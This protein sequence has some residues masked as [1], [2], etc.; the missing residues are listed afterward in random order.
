VTVITNS[1]A[2]VIAAQSSATAAVT[3]AI[4]PN[5]V[6]GEGTGR[7][8]HPTLGTFDYQYMPEQW[9]NMDGSAIIKPSWQNSKT[10]DSGQNTLWGGNIKDVECKEIWTAPGGLAMPMSQLRV[11]ISFFQNPPDPTVDYVQWWPSY[12]TTNGF[13]VVIKG[14]EVGGEGFTFS[15]IS[16]QGWID[17]PVT[18][19]YQIIGPAS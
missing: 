18:M 1:T 15:D 7:L 8:I 17:L 4:I 11:L 10:L 3:L 2:F 13:D 9:V 14:M 12:V 5:A 6:A 19:I 16:L